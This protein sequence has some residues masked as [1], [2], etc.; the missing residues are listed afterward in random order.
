MAPP[1]WILEQAIEEHPRHTSDWYAGYCRF[2][3]QWTR[4]MCRKMY[5]QG[6]LTIDLS[7]EGDHVYELVDT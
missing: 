5:R 6:K 3:E 2:N 7:I 4:E 1:E